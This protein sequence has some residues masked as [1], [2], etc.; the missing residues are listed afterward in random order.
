MKKKLRLSAI[1]MILVMC[2]VGCGTDKA[3]DVSKDDIQSVVDAIVDSTVDD[4][5]DNA[6]ETVDNNIGTTSTPEVKDEGQT[7]E[8]PD[9][10]EILTPVDTGIV[11]VTIIAPLIYEPMQRVNTDGLDSLLTTL[12]VYN[13]TEAPRVTVNISRSEDI[14][15]SL[16]EAAEE[17]VSSNEA[18]K[19]S[20]TK[21]LGMEASVSVN[22]VI[23]NGA[24]GTIDDG[25]VLGH[26]GV[27]LTY[28][29]ANI[30]EDTEIEVIPIYNLKNV[31]VGTTYMYTP[32]HILATVPV[33]EETSNIH[34]L[35]GAF[36][37]NEDVI[38]PKANGYD[39]EWRV[40][41]APDK[42]G[43]TKKVYKGLNN[44]WL[45]IQVHKHPMDRFEG[46]YKEKVYETQPGV[47]GTTSKFLIKYTD[48][49]PDVV[50]MS[51][52]GHVYTSSDTENVI[53][54]GAYHTMTE[55]AGEIRITINECLRGNWV[56][57]VYKRGTETV[58]IT[59]TWE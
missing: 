47:F 20:A 22:D 35:L 3:T 34:V 2:I 29:E 38:A 32:C 36:I 8:T 51:P 54:G 12:S 52:N 13:K 14:Y 7:E 23:L 42:Y 46:E 59:Y 41:V 56:V 24:Y 55:I 39:V 6:D 1:L 10:P 5:V 26:N 57:R 17:F 19:A 48:A 11:T 15:T 50:L 40:Q 27:K 25:S 18:V 45:R 44:F 49:R 53:D 9:T 30:K 28:L 4:I 43:T 58:N 21:L 16:M 33:D 31:A 37:A